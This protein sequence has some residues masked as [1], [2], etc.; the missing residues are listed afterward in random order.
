MFRPDRK[1]VR[2]T[3]YKKLRFS[4]RYPLGFVLRLGF[5]NSHRI[6]R[7]IVAGF[8]VVEVDFADQLLLTLKVYWDDESGE[9]PFWLSAFQS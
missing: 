5:R 6:R 4:N 3:E 8:L 7:L 1:Y 2:L 9:V